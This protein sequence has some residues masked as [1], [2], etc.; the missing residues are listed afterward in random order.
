MTPARAT[1]HQMETQRFCLVVAYLGG[2]YRGW[3]R[4]DNAPSVQAEVEKALRTVFCGLRVTVEGSGRT[5]AGVHA[6]GQVVH[7]DLPETIPASNLLKALNF[8]LPDTVRILSAASV[9]K[10]F[11]SRKSARGKCYSYQI[12]WDG[13][14]ALP[15]WQTL[16]SAQ[17]RPP[18]D[19]DCMTT[20]VSLFRGRHDWA[21]FTV[22][23][24]VT[25]TTVRTVFSATAT[26]K[27]HGMKLE[28]VGNGFLRYQIRR[29]VGA[30]LQVGWGQFDQG[31]FEALLR[32]DRHAGDVF[33]APAQGLTLEK[34]YFRTPTPIP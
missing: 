12:R 2:S 3:Q 30:L 10:T 32:S 13:A 16:R 7:V 24:P 34:V 9:P 5:D 26:V 15:P 8:N 25:R 22:A 4:Q 19:P 29:M 11:H 6:R 20:L 23:H 1:M 21:P 31:W 27:P 18:R 17:I 28:F 14:P 33:T